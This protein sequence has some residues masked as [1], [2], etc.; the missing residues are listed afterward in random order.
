M[1]L[2]KI[3][4]FLPADLTQI[5]SGLNRPECV[6]AARDGSLYTGDWTFGIA[7]IAPDGTTGPAVE[8]DLIAQG[9]RPNGIALT[10]DGEFLFANMGRAGGVWRVGRR[11][12]AHPFATEVAGN[13]IPRTNFVLV[14][15][16]RVWIT[17]SSSA[18]KHEH[19]TAEEN[20][21]Q[22]LLVQDGKVSVAADGLNWTNELRISPDGK[23]LFVNE[24]FACRTTRYDVT[25][26]GLLRNP[27]RLTYPGDT[28]PDGMAF[29]TEG[30]LWIACVISNRLIRVA[31]DLTWTVLF[32][33]FE[34]SELDT[35]S[36]THAERRLTWDQIAQS[37]GSRLSNL[38]SIAF[39]GPDL[40]TLYLGGLGISEVQMLRSPVPGMPME[41]WR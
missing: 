24:T 41:H 26:D 39:G 1:A 16:D 34:P 27:A 15:G 14:D 2:T 38:S 10:A 35:I 18:R 33:D 12:E 23:S 17:I 13:P 25:A 9:F 19:F 20:T 22:I 29:D 36:A 30:A 4:P 31:P 8:A 7:R 21:G 11:G 5:G 40:K 28:F 37:R 3:E 6:L 32:E